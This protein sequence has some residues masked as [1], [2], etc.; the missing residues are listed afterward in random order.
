LTDRTDQ[1]PSDK[2]ISL[3]QISNQVRPRMDGYFFSGEPQ[4][5]VLS[6]LRHLA[7]IAN[8]SRISEATLLWI[9]EDFM[10]SPASESFRA[11]AHATW[12]AAIHW[13]LITF[14]PESSL[15]QAVR[16]LNLAIQGASEKVKQFGLRVQLE[17][18]ILGSLVSASEVKS[19]FSQGLSEP[20][21][22]MFVAHQPSHELL[23][24][25]PLAVLV[26]RAELLETG[27]GPR[28]STSRTSGRNVLPIL[29]SPETTIDEGEGRE[30]QPSSVLSVD[31]GVKAKEVVCFVCYIPG[32]W[33]IECPCLTHLSAEEK[34]DIAVRRR[35]YYSNVGSRRNRSPSDL[36]Q[37]EPAAKW[38][39]PGW[40]KNQG[41]VPPASIWPA[42]VVEKNKHFA[43]SEK[44]PA[45]P[46]T[47]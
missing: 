1:L 37:G 36:T 25:T 13:L 28:S 17:A 18:S 27:I 20:I 26:S 11:Q 47:S 7:R 40:K 33:W 21:R 9:V 22:S 46:K 16:K 30:E 15:E 29:A 19:L 35:T 45:A 6:F 42:T 39:R 3:T 14:A 32:H 31:S 38:G 23:D 44:V 2:S 34:E 12:P 43:S 10:Q 8:Q 4:L 24:S 5:K 41:M